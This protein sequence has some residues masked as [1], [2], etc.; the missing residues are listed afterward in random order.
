M[1]VSTRKLILHNYLDFRKKPSLWTQVICYYWQSSL[2]NPIFDDFTVKGQNYQSL[3]ASYINV[4]LN[5]YQ[6]LKKTSFL[7]LDI[8]KDL[9]TNIEL[10][11]TPNQL[12]TNDNYVR[13]KKKSETSKTQQKFIFNIDLEKSRNFIKRLL[14]FLGGQKEALTDS[15]NKKMVD[16]HFEKKPQ[17]ESAIIAWG[18]FSPNTAYPL[19]LLEVTIDITT[20]KVKGKLDSFA[21]IN[22]SFFNSQ[23]EMN[24]HTFGD[25]DKVLDFQSKNPAPRSE[26]IEE[27]LKYAEKFMKKVYLADNFINISHPNPYY[28]ENYG[29]KWQLSIRLYKYKSSSKDFFLIDLYQQIL[30]GINED[31]P[32]L[33]KS[34]CTRTQ[35][36]SV[37]NLKLKSEIAHFRNNGHCGHMDSQYPLDT[38]QRLG[39]IHFL[40]TPLGHLQA[41]NGPPGTGKTSML[42]GVIA[43]LFVT[44]LLSDEKSPKPPLILASSA[45]N[46]AV[47]NII[48]SFAKFAD[49]SDKPTVASRWLTVETED[50]ITSPAPSFGWFF[51]SGS[52]RQDAGIHKYQ[53]LSLSKNQLNYENAAQQLS[54]FIDNKEEL[55]DNYINSF[56]QVF[57]E[58]KINSVINIVQFIQYQIKL[59]HQHKLNAFKSLFKIQKSQVAQYIKT[60]NFHINQYALNPK[61][62]N[63]ELSQLLKT[64]TIYLSDRTSSNLDNL[65]EQFERFCDITYRVYSFH[66]AA[67][68]WEGRWLLEDSTIDEQVPLTQEKKEK[69]RIQQL[70]QACM[71]API[72]V[73][74][75][76][77]L[78][79][80]FAISKRVEGNTYQNYYLT[81]EA[82][83]LIMDEAGQVVPEIGGAL[84]ALAK[85]ALIVGDIYQL[86]PI[87][88]FTPLAD[89]ALLHQV[90]LLNHQKKLIE[91]GFSVSLGSLMKMA[92]TAT[93]YS[94]QDVPEKGILLTRHY[95]CYS[96]IIEFCNELVYQGQLIPFRKRSQEEELVFG[97]PLLYVGHSY[98]GTKLNGSWGN[99]K[100]AKE[101]AQ[102][103]FDNRKKLENFY[104]EK[105]HDLATIVAIVTPYVPQKAILEKEL[106]ALFGDDLG[107]GDLEIRSY[108]QSLPEGESQKPEKTLIQ[109]MTIGTVHALQGAER[110]IIIFSPVVHRQQGEALFFDRD[111]SMLNVAIS[112]AKDCLI[113]IGHDNTFFPQIKSL[114]SSDYPSLKLGN[115]LKKRGKRL[116]PRF[117]VVVE[118]PNKAKKLQDLL[119]RDFQVF[120]TKGHFQELIP[121]GKGVNIEQ[122]FEPNWQISSDKESI[123]K[124]IGRM[125]EDADELILATDDDREGEEIARQ[126]LNYLE[127]QI[128][129]DHLSISRVRLR[130]MSADEIE[131]SFL[132]RGELIEPLAE[133][134]RTRRVLDYLIGGLLFEV[135]KEDADL[136]EGSGRVQAAILSLLAQREKVIEQVQAD[137]IW[138]VKTINQWVHNGSQQ[139]FES[140]LAMD[141]YEDIRFSLSE[142]EAQEYARKLLEKTLKLIEETEQVKN[143]EITTYT[144]GQ[145]PALTTAEMIR[146]ASERLGLLPDETMRLLQKLYEGPAN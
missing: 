138:R 125:L 87:S 109:R 3:E 92:Q 115:Y 121:N 128:P 50:G 123:L 42:K 91:D 94:E 72:I 136:W 106:K 41:I 110:P 10:P 68:Y 32:D 21:L 85:R 20:G 61:Q 2:K 119:G 101:I 70:Q 131:R 95:R 137:R 130:G 104:Q 44:P 108:N 47:T 99:V 45:T 51:P 36:N 4:S 31:V 107:K 53:V 78:P 8:L 67:R 27:K 88:S 60:L 141:G 37:L 96:E 133:A 48:S 90:R 5:K 6:E 114:N 102:W 22:R 135:L 52:K 80:L 146:R 69:R 127:N 144:L 58:Q 71:I 111:T 19:L 112:R 143:P 29:R 122:N 129:L 57:L 116:Y 83:L 66:L 76:Y 43:S 93:Y 30:Q 35:A 34:L 1:P 75:A 117:C 103:L 38:T 134:A 86:S 25:F 39:V 73:A 9:Y 89:E 54:Q 28:E 65:I 59:T 55:I 16:S 64:L 105:E 132:E 63:Q 142:Q 113:L 140:Y 24:E 56:R 98:Q 12:V 7:S 15:I 82:D 139:T 79:K 118:S 77:T 74:T 33:L 126:V 17:E 11:S 124:E 23:E 18:F 46:Q 97:N 84:F 13:K 14:S 100:E 120:A 62:A 40:E 81:S 26:K 49:K 145:A